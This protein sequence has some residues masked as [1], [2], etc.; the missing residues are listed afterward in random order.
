MSIFG[1]I[2]DA[3]F[4]KAKAAP[5]SS[6]ANSATPEGAQGGPAIPLGSQAQPK[7]QDVD[8]DAVLAELAA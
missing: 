1:K 7:P 2:K 3:I 8:V 6:P 5:T 4:G